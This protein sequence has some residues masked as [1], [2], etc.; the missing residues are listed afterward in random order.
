MDGRRD[1]SSASEVTTLWRY[2]NMLIII[3]IIIVSLSVRLSVR[4]FV[5]LFVRFICQGRPSYGGIE[6]RCFI[7]I[8]GG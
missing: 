3:I 5:C 4:P 8:R 2:T 7:E 6:P 1:A